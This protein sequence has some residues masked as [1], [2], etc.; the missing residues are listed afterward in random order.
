MAAGQKEWA[1][2]D[3]MRRLDLISSPFRD[4]SLPLGQIVSRHGSQRGH[5]T[6]GMSVPKIKGVNQTAII[7]GRGGGDEKRWLYARKTHDGRNDQKEAGQC[8]PFLGAEKGKSGRLTRT[9]GRASMQT[10]WHGVTCMT[11]CCHAS[12][13]L[14]GGLLGGR[15]A[16]SN[17]RVTLRR[18]SSRA[19]VSCSKRASCSFTEARMLAAERT[20]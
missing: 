13:W 18:S 15:L 4:E 11:T 14:V 6:K 5:Q 20:S 3:G 17:C 10:C 16:L 9:R 7:G 2:D 1:Q 12:G 19:R 8:R